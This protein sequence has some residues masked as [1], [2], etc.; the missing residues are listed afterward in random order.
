MSPSPERWRLLEELYQ[1]AVE[2][3]PAER[4]L[5]LR[6]ACSDEDLR[7]EVESLLRFENQGDTFLQQSPWTQ[8]PKLAPG[9]R[10][11]PYEVETR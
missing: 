5:Y 3:P 8:P 1:A 10:L 2:H 4:A 7:R 9:L 11:G 6:E